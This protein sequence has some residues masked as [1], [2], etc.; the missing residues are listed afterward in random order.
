MVTVS[1]VVTIALVVQLKQGVTQVS[2]LLY[3]VV[4]INFNCF[5]NEN[6]SETGYLQKGC[7]FT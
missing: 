2:L 7:H 1:T 5:I 4:N 6:F 3:K